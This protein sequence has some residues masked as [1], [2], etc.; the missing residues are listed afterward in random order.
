MASVLYIIIVVVVRQKLKQNDKVLYK[1][2][3]VIMVRVSDIFTVSK[4]SQ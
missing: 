2:Y 3:N 1:V 4:L